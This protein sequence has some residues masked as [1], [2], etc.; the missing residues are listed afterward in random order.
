[1]DGRRWRAT[2]R[3]GAERLLSA[4]RVANGYR[5]GRADLSDVWLPGRRG[6]PCPGVRLVRGGLRGTGG[7]QVLLDELSG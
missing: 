7:C 5:G 1:M 6:C 4:E 2:P 3:D